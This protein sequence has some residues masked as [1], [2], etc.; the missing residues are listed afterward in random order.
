MCC[1]EE[2]GPCW[3][4]CRSSSFDASEVFSFGVIFCF[5][6]LHKV[7]WI[8][9][10]TYLFLVILFY[11]FLM[12]SFRNTELEEA[13][14]H[15]NSMPLCLFNRLY[16]SPLKFFVFVCVCVFWY[17]RLFPQ[18]DLNNSFLIRKLSS[19]NKCYPSSPS[20]SS[21][22]PEVISPSKNT[23]LENVRVSCF[24]QNNSASRPLNPPQL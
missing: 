15:C 21:H 3:G 12:E 1:D 22:P 16:C 4:F 6:L 5:F 7:T 10:K 13:V 18:T 19:H 11:L 9:I 14:Y 2:R 24:W 20:F 8:A 23:C 17:W